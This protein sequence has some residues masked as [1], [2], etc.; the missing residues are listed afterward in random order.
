MQIIHKDLKHG[1]VKLKVTVLDDLWYLSHLI[2][3]G[4]EISG[5]TER[6][7]KLGTGEERQVK[8]IKKWVTL[9]IHAAKVEFHPSATILRV[10]G[11]ILEGPEDVPRGSYHTIN[12]E[13]QS[14]VVI[15]KEKWLTY[16]IERLGEATKAKH[17]KILILVLD[18]E[19]ALF[20]L[21]KPS[22]YQLLSS[23]KGE[24]QRKRI[25][26]QKKGSF[27][28]DLLKLIVEYDTRYKLDKIII[29]SPAFW[30]EDLL[31]ELKDSECRKKII[32]AT[33]SDAGEHGIQEV[34]KRPETQHA[35]H[36][37]R[38]S[39]EMT[40]VEQLLQEISKD[41]LAAY[42][43]TETAAAVDAGAVQ[44][45]LITDSFIQH[46]RQ[47]GTYEAIDQLLKMTDAAKGEIMMVSNDHE[48]GKKLDGLGGIAALLRWKLAY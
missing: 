32:L 24:V 35:L 28:A 16:Q 38:I 20:A 5:R 14:I 7:I 41:K 11:K 27:Y 42:G 37:D 17:P 30:K 33:C 43:I 25:S 4:D 6:K 13:E 46:A 2:D 12:V 48:G 8:I 44:T 3:P 31:K 21:M 15:Q 29:G 40:L 36:E 22:G 19:E 47:K 45:L 10:S 39:K 1:K 34:L 18:R 23:I 26:E 9:T